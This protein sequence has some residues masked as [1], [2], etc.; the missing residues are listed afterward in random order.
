VKRAPTFV[1]VAVLVVSWQ[2]H[3]VEKR[4]TKMRTR[5]GSSPHR[6]WHINGPIPRMMIYLEY[7]K[8]I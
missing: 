1:V 4:D 6:I 7:V 8:R 3:C 2:L 5:M